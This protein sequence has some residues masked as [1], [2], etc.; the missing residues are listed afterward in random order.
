MSKFRKQHMS[1]DWHG[2]VD[3]ESMEPAI[4]ASLSEKATLVGRIGLMM[5]SVGTAAWRVRASMNKLAR[6]LDI[7][8]N[9]DIGLLSIEYT[10]IG[11]GETYTN[12]ISLNNTGVNTDKLNEL[13]NFADGFAERVGKYSVQQFH[14][15]LDKF[16]DMKGNYK[17]WNLGLASALACCAFTFLLGGGIVEMICAFFGAGVGN[18]VRKKMLEKQITLFANVA[19]GVASACCTY[20]LFIKLAELLLNV[21]DIH[22]A[23]Y[24]C[25]M[26]F[27][28][29]GFPLITGGM[30]LAKLDLRSGIERVTY[31]LLIILVATLTGWVSALIFNFHPQDFEA[32]Q[33][34]P[35]LRFAIT[36][37]TSF[38]GVYGFS[39]MFNSTRKM[40]ATAGLIGMIA[41]TL[42]LEL[43]DMAEIHVGLAAFIGALTAGLLASA[44]HHWIGYPRIT[45]TVPSIVIMVP[46]MFMYKGIYYIALNDIATGG[47]WLTKAVL[48]VAALPLGLIFA[49]IITDKNFRKSS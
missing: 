47:L 48:I 13:E 37:I 46:G 8:C 21:S 10:C 36:M 40:A 26:L 20:V 39:L 16:Q 24:I 5:L 44:I 29:P 34:D 25:S 1:I 2:V 19:I 3:S 4:N 30:D 42:R 35:L 33:L 17:A 41:N 43:I 18:F 31:A 22:Q 23:G 14:M 32:Y 9:A 12:A 27:V 45:L 38:C 49:R 11:N 28:I 6:A 15:I 7:T